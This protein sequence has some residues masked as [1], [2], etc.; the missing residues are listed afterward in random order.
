MTAA[1]QSFNSSDPTP[2]ESLPALDAVNFFVGGVLAGFGP[3]VAPFL[4]GRGWSPENVGFVLTAGG[5]AGV[6]AQI[7]GGELLDAARSKRFGLGA[8]I[9]AVGSAPS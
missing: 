3:F 7:P 4:G 2:A 9:T 8:G 6:L 1:P 5:I